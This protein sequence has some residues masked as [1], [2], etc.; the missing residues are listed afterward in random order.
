[1]LRAYINGSQAIDNDG[2]VEEALAVGM[3]GIQAANR[4]GLDRAGGDQLS[5]QAAWRLIRLG[6]YAEAGRV[7]R[8]A[9]ENATLSF[10]IA[11]TRNV[12]GY[13]AAVRGEFERAEALLDEA[14]EQMQHSGG[15]QL[16]GLAL[17]WRI[18]LC[19]WQDKRERAGRLA[20]E[21]VRRATEA[22]GQLIYTAELYWL[23]TRVEA[24]R[25]LRART[26]GD[27]FDAGR[28][29]HEAEGV[30]GKLA[31]AIAGYPGDGAPPEALA[32][33]LL[34]RAELG[35]SRG[36]TPTG[37]WRAAAQA[38]AGLGQVARAAYAEMREAE[39]LAI[40]GAPS[41]AIAEPL[42][43]AHAVAVDCG[44]APFR[45]E[46]EELAR[47]ARVDLPD[48]ALDRRT[49]AERLGLTEREAEVLALLTEG[50]TNRQI[51]QELFIT[52]KTAS[53]HVSRILMKLG[54]SNRGEA[55]AAAHRVGLVRPRVP[56]S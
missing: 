27:R 37:D 20:Q 53:V 42:R 21:G 41:R 29:T 5:M 13:L 19:L 26:V 51:G 54:V 40:A 43:R 9:F 16:I 31:E 24:D 1:M 52:E 50:R 39:A 10:N 34:V 36:E 18:A 49:A 28:T 45:T 25:A 8:P 33:E 35:R 17:A 7:I 6:R 46:V 14:W 12:A 3:Q 56:S 4:L 2:R 30:A 44:I 48:Q 22:E 38:F 15:L 47:R 11:A 32:F 55:A 23:A